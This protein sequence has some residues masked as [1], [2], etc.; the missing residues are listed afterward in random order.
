MERAGVGATPPRRGH[1]LRP[2]RVPPAIGSLRRPP[3]AQGYWVLLGSPSQAV[4]FS[5]SP[6][7]LPRDWAPS[8]GTLDYWLSRKSV[9]LDAQAGSD[10]G[11]QVRGRRIWAKTDVMEPA[12]TSG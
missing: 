8:L 11:S 9:L 10:L 4:G 2:R 6:P 1:W 12:R 5:Q 3:L 7:P